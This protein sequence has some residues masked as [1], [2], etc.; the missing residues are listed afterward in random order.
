MRA[1]PNHERIA[2]DIVRAL[3]QILRR[4]ERELSE[5]RLQELA[6]LDD[7]DIAEENGVKRRLS[8]KTIREAAKQEL[9]RREAEREKRKKYF[10][11]HCS[12]PIPIARPLFGSRI[13]C[14]RCRES[15]VCA[16]ENYC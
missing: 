3:L 4:H 8:C 14:P 10:C 11:P 9:A 13:R 1:V 6:A 16:E 12:F 5:S 2:A 7:V 15:H